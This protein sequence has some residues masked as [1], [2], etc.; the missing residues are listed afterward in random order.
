MLRL[1]NACTV[2]WCLTLVFWSFIHRHSW[3]FSQ[4]AS[5][6]CKLRRF[7]SPSDRE[8]DL[9]D[10]F[11]ALHFSKSSRRVLPPTPK[12]DDQVY[13]LVED[14]KDDTI[15]AVVRFCPSK[16]DNYVLLRSLCVSRAHRRQGLALKLIQEAVDD[17]FDRFVETGTCY[18][19]ADKS[20]QKLYE[21]AHFELVQHQ[22]GATP[23]WMWRSFRVVSRRMKRKH[24]DMKLFVQQRGKKI[25][26]T[27]SS[28]DEV[29]SVILLQ[30]CRESTRPTSTAPLVFG[31]G[32]GDDETNLS[33]HLN[34]TVWSWSGRVDNPIIEKQ[35]EELTENGGISP[36]LLWTGGNGT[37]TTE[38]THSSCSNTT[39][40]IIL[41][42][43]WQEA[44]T[45]FRKLSFLQTLPRFSIH[46]QTESNF[47]L[48]RDYTGWKDRFRDND[49]T[50]LCTAE[51]IAALLDKYGDTT[52]GNIVRMRLQEFQH[53]Y[54]KKH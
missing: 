24:Q 3:A 38:S 10:S 17:Y 11:Y 27:A 2:S 16:Q 39:S 47:T 12:P 48:R 23:D 28:C 51:V 42:G 31:N 19:F 40:F 36:V 21:R 25:V 8:K 50:L 52:G 20:L 46:S 43:T 1:Y 44:R 13:A 9:L 49:V 18:C 6:G 15:V 33:R 54:G 30:H 5:N 37:V 41:D 32:N 26:T 4:S 45:M 22:T 14:S 53:N 35:L 34:V 7:V 29:L